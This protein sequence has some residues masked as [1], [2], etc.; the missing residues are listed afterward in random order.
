[1]YFNLAYWKQKAPIPI[2]YQYHFEKVFNQICFNKVNE[3]A[4]L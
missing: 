3:Q 1:M 2:N 4:S